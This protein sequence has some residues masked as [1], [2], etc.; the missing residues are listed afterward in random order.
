MIAVL[1]FGSQYTHLIT[2]RLRELG[3]YAEIFPHDISTKDLPVNIKGIILS[4]GPASVYEKDSPSLKKEIL[5]SNI[6]ILGIC[7]GQQLLAYLLGGKIIPAKSREYGKK[8]VKIKGGALYKGLAKKET[9]WYSHGDTVKELP[10]GFKSNA[11]SGNEIAG[12]EHQSSDKK[13]FAVQFHPEVAHTQNGSKI[14][15]NF[16][17]ISESKSNWKIEDQIKGLI[18]EIKDSIQNEHCLIGVSGGIDSLVASLLLH[19]AIGQKLYSVFI[20]TGLM[21]KNEAEDVERI[22]SKL[23]FKNFIS[24]DAKNE[25]LSALK[26]ISDPEGKRK[27]I[28]HTFIRVFEKVAS[29]L[30]K[31]KR[32]KF[33]AQGTIYPD[34]V[35]SAS[36]SKTSQK[37][38]S[39]HNLTLPK[40]LNFQIIEPL[41]EFYK[42]EVRIL[43]KKLGVAPEFLNRH[44]FPGPGL[45]IRVLGE[46]TEDKLDLLREADAIYIEELKKARLLSKIWQAFAALIPVKTVG[47]MGDLR[48]YEYIISLRA[49]TSKDGMTADWAK[50]PLPI[51]E[52]ISSRI[53]N[54][55][56]GVNRVVYDIT[57]KPPGT[58]E[59]E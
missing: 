10:Q 39:H 57:Q 16:L 52:K 3:T 44:P 23:N 17:K 27:V 4:G 47:V 30:K 51:L 18:K 24:I 1:D 34:R 32:I 2:R 22:Y 45:A 42:D 13:I 43:G 53:I 15:K 48:T 28:G 37:I 50:I 33:L 29:N 58:I 55:V 11:Y 40:K 26:E 31:Q 56:K 46:I 35:E 59:Y 14:L 41:R 25:F 21:R 20:D 9:V 36:T 8:V 5:E 54:E 6:P 38:K 12:F 7:Y 49:V 19:K